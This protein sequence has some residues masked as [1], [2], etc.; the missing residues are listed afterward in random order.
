MII[1]NQFLLLS[2]ANYMLGPLN[3]GNLRITN[4]SDPVF[5]NDA[6]TKGYVDSLT[7]SL[8]IY[9]AGATNYLTQLTTNLYDTV[10][11]RAFKAVNQTV[12]KTTWTKV[13]YEAREYDSLGLFNT[14]LSRFVPNQNGFYQLY[15]TVRYE[16]S[17]QGARELA[18]YRNGIAHAYGSTVA[19]SGPSPLGVTVSDVI[20]LTTNDYIEVY[21]Y[22]SSNGDTVILSNQ[23]NS[24][25]S[26]YK[27]N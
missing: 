2:G 10:K 17:T 20:D 26:I 3:A 9:F 18:V 19:A 16:Q 13:A 27:L 12:P 11:V 15:A 14:N 5:F 6:A 1:S 24:F 21:T 8:S 4:V 25:F 23:V 22:Q 7:N